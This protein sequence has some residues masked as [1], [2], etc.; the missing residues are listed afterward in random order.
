VTILPQSMLPQ[1]RQ[2]E[3]QMLGWVKPDVAPAANFAAAPAVVVPTGPAGRQ[4]VQS[5]VVG[6]KLAWA[7][8]G[9]LVVLTS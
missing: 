9:G 8:E 1:L 6:H 4:K 2:A 5:L 7:D 3:D